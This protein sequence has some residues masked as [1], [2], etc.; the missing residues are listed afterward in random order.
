M[1]ARGDL[2]SK[3]SAA[4]QA[5]DR[6]VSGYLHEKSTWEEE[7]ARMNAELEQLRLTSQ[8]RMIRMKPPADGR[9]K[10]LEAR[11]AALQKE[12]DLERASAKH[13]MESLERQATESRP[14]VSTEVAR[15][16][17]LILDI[18]KKINDPATALT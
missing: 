13:Q 11:I 15:V 5:R 2:E 7:K 3:L 10:E 18:T 16:E 17:Q 4:V 6:A 1:S 14:S 12:L 9:T 8:P